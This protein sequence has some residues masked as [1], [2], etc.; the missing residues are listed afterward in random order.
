VNRPWLLPK[1]RLRPRSGIE[2][3]PQRI[4]PRH[5]RF[6]RSH[7]CCV[8]GCEATEVDF[9]H[10]RSAANAGKDLKPF[11][12]FGVSLCRQHHDQQHTQGVETFQRHHGI[13][14]WA[15]AAEFASRSPDILMRAAMPAR[16]RT[17]WAKALFMPPLLRE[18][19]RG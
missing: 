10:L 18:M 5:R 11:D 19:A 4:W 14:L 9:A 3:A 12:W 7:A 2:R 15:I 17:P 16:E 1:K 6:V 13:D 8:T